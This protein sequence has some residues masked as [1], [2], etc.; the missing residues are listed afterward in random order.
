MRLMFDNTYVR[1]LPGTYLAVE[2]WLK[3]EALALM[4]R[5]LESEYMHQLIHFLQL[6]QL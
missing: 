6:Q 2:R 5:P 1:D 3:G 4:E